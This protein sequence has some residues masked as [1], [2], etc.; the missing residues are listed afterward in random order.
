MRIETYILGPLDS[1]CYL[2]HDD[3]H[4]AAI[5]DPGGE[6]DYL[7]ELIIRNN[8]D[9]RHILLTHAHYDHVLGILPLKLNFNCQVY[10]HEKDAP[11][12]KNA[13]SSHSHWHNRS[14]DPLPSPDV[15]YKKGEGIRIGISE[16][17][18]IETPGHTP[19]SV[20]LY[21]EGDSILFTGDTLFRRGVGRTDF[22]YSNPQSLRMSLEKLKKLPGET[23]I[24]PGHGEPST[25]G[26]E[27]SS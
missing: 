17:T 16:L 6:G 14:S 9:L 5:I 1:N 19:G 26:D 8:L 21:L 27:L 7:S 11:L 13:T 25:I 10:L 15:F 12:Y 3:T 20:C 2:L 23:T 24:Y 18:V 22:S 4:E